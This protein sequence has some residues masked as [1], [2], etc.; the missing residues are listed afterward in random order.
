MKNRKNIMLCIAATVLLMVSVGCGKTDSPE[1]DTVGVTENVVEEISSTTETTIISPVQTTSA[2][3]ES[4]TEAV[5]TTSEIEIITES[6]T[7]EIV[8]TTEKTEKPSSVRGN[9]QEIQANE[10]VVTKNEASVQQIVTS[11]K[12]EPVRTTVT[13]KKVTTQP[14]VTTTTAQNETPVCEDV[15]VWDIPARPQVGLRDRAYLYSSNVAD[16]SKWICGIN[17]DKTVEVIGQCID[18]SVTGS[19]V[20]YK[21]KYKDYVGYME[22]RYLMGIDSYCEASK[23]APIINDL[24]NSIGESSLNY[25]DNLEQAAMIRAKELTVLY[26]HLRPNGDGGTS[27]INEYDSDAYYCGENIYYCSSISTA[28]DVSDAWKASD[29]HYHTMIGTDFTRF[30][31]GVYHYNG[32][33]FAVVLFAGDRD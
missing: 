11:Q 13:T 33:T 4:S 10:P 21:V 12:K 25:S 22:A 16:D 15:P 32:G 23:V 7:A 26:D 18:Y 1:S 2:T 17:P 31:I 28:Q 19:P 30:G 20:W 6:T 9:A 3:D 29:G 5:I 8:S 14:P 27:A 24:R